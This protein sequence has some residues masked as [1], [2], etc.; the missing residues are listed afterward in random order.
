MPVAISWIEASRACVAHN[1]ICLRETESLIDANRR[2]LNP[3]WGLSGS[4]DTGPEEAAST[5]RSNGPSG[6]I[7]IVREKHL[8]DPTGPYH[9]V[10]SFGGHKDP[11][12]AIVLGQALGARDL[13]FLL[14]RF[15][16]SEGA[17][18]LALKEL[19]VQNQ[20][21]ISGV[22]LRKGQLGHL[23]T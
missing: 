23:R 1:L 22:T 8:D 21:I 15:G 10:V 19:V 13:V 18:T 3:W 4:S 6:V 14:R 17:A 2:A 9:F 12:G 11:V 5:R 16:V 20:H 7:H